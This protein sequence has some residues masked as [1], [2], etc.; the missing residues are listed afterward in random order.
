[1]KNTVGGI[2]GNTLRRYLIV[3]LVASLAITG[4]MFAYAFTTSTATITAT[5]TTDFS[6]IGPNTT[7][8]CAYSIFGNYSG[9][10]PAGNIF[11]LNVTAGHNGDVSV[12][13]YLDNIDQLGKNYGLWLMRLRLCDHGPPWNHQ[14]IEMVDKPLTLRNGVVTF[15]SDNLVDINEYVIRC[16]GG[17]YRAHPW[18]YITRGGFGTI[19]PSVTA[20]VLQAQ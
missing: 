6:E 11:S 17:I 1:M 10:I 12:N 15:V 4:G 13:V 20:E 7:D 19:N 5:G 14:S 3:A 9:A 16:T 2:K 18:A 8:P